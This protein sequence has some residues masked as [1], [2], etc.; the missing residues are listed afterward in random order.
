[1][2]RRIQLPLGTMTTE[3]HC[4]DCPQQTAPGYCDVFGNTD[5]DDVDDL[6]HRLC[7]AAEVKE[8]DDAE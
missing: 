5:A 1:M 4:V 7:R 3:T 6:R 2:T 8:K